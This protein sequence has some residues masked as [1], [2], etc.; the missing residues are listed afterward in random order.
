MNI[1]YRNAI[2]NDEEELF[3]LSTKLSTSFKLDKTDFR[4]TFREV[5]S[6]KDADLFVAENEL[7][8]IGYVLAFHHSTLYAN[9]LISWVEELFVLEDYRGKSVGKNLMVLIEEKAAKR[10][11][12]LI[13][14][15]TRRASDFYKGIGYDESAVYLKKSLL[16]AD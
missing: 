8:L 1:S 11:S 2:S 3:N 14:L 16:R 5:L 4:Q 15:A 9:G 12:K 7:G 10:D 6:N 13:A